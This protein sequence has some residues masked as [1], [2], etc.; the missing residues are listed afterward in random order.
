MINLGKKEKEVPCFGKEGRSKSH[1]GEPFAKPCKTIDSFGKG[2]KVLE[3]TREVSSS[4]SKITSEGGNLTGRRLRGVWEQ[5]SSS[6]QD[7]VGKMPI[8]SGKEVVHA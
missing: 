8:F 4:P 5:C 1:R 7:S 6:A 2:E 3:K